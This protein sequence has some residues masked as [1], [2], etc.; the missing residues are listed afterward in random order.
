MINPCFKLAITRMN[1][2]SV[3]TAV[4]VTAESISP[5]S[6]EV[7][8]NES[9]CAD[10]YLITASPMASESSEEVV[11][12]E[13]TDLN[14][15]IEE[16]FA[17]KKY[18]IS[19]TSILRVDEAEDNNYFEGEPASVTAST[20]LDAAAIESY[21]LSTLNVRS[22]RTSAT[23]SWSKNEWPCAENET[24]LVCEDDDDNCIE[25][26]GPGIIV[27]DRVAF[28]VQG[29]KSCTL[30]TVSKQFFRRRLRK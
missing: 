17:C 9:S 22:G 1:A 18:Q 4:N 29:L 30:Y 2:F 6:I 19:V 11:S 16:L 10:G 14:V 20:Q 7:T 12:L 3:P 24:V 23:F 26:G 5:T 27:D 21:R 15:T 25:A 8:W 28:T 13:T